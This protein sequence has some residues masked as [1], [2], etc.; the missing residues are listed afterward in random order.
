[1]IRGT[2]A[3]SRFSIAFAAVAASAIALAHDIW[4]QPSACRVDPDA[5]IRL[6]LR[7]GNH[8]SGHKDFRLASKVAGNAKNLVL[9]GPDGAKVDLTGSLTDQGYGEKEG[10][11]SARY[12]PQ[13]QG[14]YTA[15]STFDQVMTYGPIRDVKSAKT[16]FAVGSVAP[17]GF[18]RVFGHD[19]E[20]VP[21][22]NPILAAGG[23]LA[24]KVL[25]K[26]KPLSG[27]KV[28]YV[29]MGATP[30][31]GDDPE[32]E[33]KTDDAGIAKASL[34]RGDIYLICARQVDPQGKGEGYEAINYSATLCLVVPNKPL[35]W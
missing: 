19:I 6:D 22:E 10:F 12:V 29:P 4:I 9:Y 21:L 32:F 13:T 35:R 27:T 5:W 16:Y 20:I 34:S 17:S 3:V 23:T 26:G 18:D 14:L 28:T 1:M 7:L 11:W 31:E 24:V 33:S 25:Y 2:K 30:K 15:V 8:G